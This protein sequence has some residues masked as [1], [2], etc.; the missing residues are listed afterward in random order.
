MDLLRYIF[1]YP[2]ETL[3]I[4]R[5]DAGKGQAMVVVS[6]KNEQW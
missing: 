3:Q 2:H 6:V 1:F 5:D 4:K